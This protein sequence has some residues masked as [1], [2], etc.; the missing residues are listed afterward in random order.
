MQLTEIISISAGGKPIFRLPNWS[1]FQEVNRLFVL[2]FE[3]ITHRT[4]HTR[5]YFPKV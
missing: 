3:N 1:R 2:S 4:G 5:Y